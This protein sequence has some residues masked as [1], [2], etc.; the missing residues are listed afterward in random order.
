MFMEK[1]FVLITGASSGIGAKIALQL[2]DKYNIILNGRDSKRLEDVRCKCAVG[3][4]LIWQYDLK[5]VNDIETRLSNFISENKKDVVYFV[6]CAGM[7]K[8]LPVKMFTVDVFS[9]TLKT[10][11]IAAAMITKVLSGKKSNNKA[12]KSVVFISSNI[13][14]FGAKA[15]SMYGSSKAAL[16]GLM[17]SL[18]MELAPSVRVNS[19]LPGGIK[20]P[21]TSHI[22]EDEE[23]V[24]RMASSY[25]LGLG[26]TSDIADAVEFLLS[27]KSRWITG[28]QITVDGGRTINLT[29]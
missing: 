21:L 2:S 5:N 9:D 12:L 6:H 24:N 20:T 10:N 27:D 15:H 16:D 13:S 22:Y 26:N 7:M 11:V 18:A 19:V 28:Q 25:P 14:N 1:E 17:R 4:H 3:D 23:L 8:N 29:V